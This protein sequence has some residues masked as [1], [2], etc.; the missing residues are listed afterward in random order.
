L[1]RRLNQAAELSG[2]IDRQPRVHGTS[3]VKKALRTPEGEDPSHLIAG[4]VV[5]TDLVADVVPHCR[6]VEH[7]RHITC[8]DSAAARRRRSPSRILYDVDRVQR[9]NRDARRGGKRTNTVAVGLEITAGEY[10]AGKGSCRAQAIPLSMWE[11]RTVTPGPT[12]SK[13][14]GRGGYTNTIAAIFAPTE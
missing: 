6:I 4:N 8:I 1:N 2:E 11:T 7:Q 9:Q 13:N 12:G 10:I 14:F 5:A 3:A